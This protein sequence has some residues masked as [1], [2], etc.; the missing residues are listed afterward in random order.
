MSWTM[1]G[2]EDL[3][4]ACAAISQSLAELCKMVHPSIVAIEAPLTIINS[5]Y[6]ARPAFVLMSLY[7]A[8]AGAAHSAG[9]RVVDGHIGTWRKAFLG[10]GNLPGK[11]AKRLAMERCEKLGWKVENHDEADAA[12]LWAWAMANNFRQWK[13]QDGS[14]LL[15]SGVAA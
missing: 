9:A 4:R 1:P 12:G 2:A 7:G 5:T 11:E 6:G 8:A 15:A 13:P 14:P 3:P 10:K